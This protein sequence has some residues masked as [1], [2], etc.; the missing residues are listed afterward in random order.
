MAVESTR[1]AQ[2]WGPKSSKLYSRKKKKMKHHRAQ[3]LAETTAGVWA[4]TVVQVGFWTLPFHSK[5]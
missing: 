5:K 4:E 1:E 3:K 2:R